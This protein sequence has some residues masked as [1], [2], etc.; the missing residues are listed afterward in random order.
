LECRGFPLLLGEAGLADLLPTSHRPHTRSPTCAPRYDD[1][2]IL[3]DAKPTFRSK[4]SLLWLSQRG[5]RR[6]GIGG[7]VTRSPLP[8]H[9]TCGSPP[10]G[11]EGYARPSNNRGRPRE[12]K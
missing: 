3:S 12:S 11:S 2:I 8:H 4:G 6:I 5:L 1:T 7:A 10:G 9:L